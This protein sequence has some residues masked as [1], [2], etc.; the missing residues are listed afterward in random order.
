MSFL[1][2]Q[3]ER[4]PGEVVSKRVKPLIKWRNARP[5]VWTKRGKPRSDGDYPTLFAIG[6]RGDLE[7]IWRSDNVGAS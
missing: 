4:P 1:T 3:G 6:T 7:A 2:C 5:G